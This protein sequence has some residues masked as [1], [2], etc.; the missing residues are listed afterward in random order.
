MLDNFAT[1]LD[2]QDFFKAFRELSNTFWFKRPRHTNLID[3]DTN[4]PHALFINPKLAQCLPRIFI[5][6]ASCHNA[7]TRLWRIDD[8]LINLVGMGES[9]CCISLLFLQA[10]IL[11]Q[12]RVG[13][14]NIQSILGQHKVIRCNDVK[15]LSFK[16]HNGAG[17]NRVGN[18]FVT[19]PTTR[20]TRHR[21]AKQTQFDELMD[22]GRKQ[23]RHDGCH[24]GMI[25]LMRYS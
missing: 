15:V 11:N 5:S 12:R 6:L 19:D 18:D 13:P 16:R 4:F 7:K 17:F 9:E 20:V 24:K 21:N 14:A 8:K 25:R 22:R 1:L 10:F 23:H 2:N 3:S